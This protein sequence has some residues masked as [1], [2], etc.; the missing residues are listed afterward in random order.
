MIKYANGNA[1]RRNAEILVS[2]DLLSASLYFHRVDA[3][4]FVA[5]EQLEKWLHHNGVVFGINRE[6]LRVIAASPSSYI[7]PV[8]IA[9]GKRAVEGKNGRVEYIYDMDEDSTRPIETE[10][11]KVNYKEVTQLRNVKRGQ[12][13]A[14]KNPAGACRAGH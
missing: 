7:H 5:F 2:D 12:L 8:I 9:E 4:Y 3:D 6:L 11:G 10:D 13:I 1:A 14:K